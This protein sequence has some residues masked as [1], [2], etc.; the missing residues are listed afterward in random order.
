MKIKLN[1]RIP[2]E[3]MYICKSRLIKNYS[4]FYNG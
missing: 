3:I 4:E 2:V 1:D